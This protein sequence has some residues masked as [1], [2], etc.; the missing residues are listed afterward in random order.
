M[1]KAEL[2]KQIDDLKRAKILKLH[3]EYIVKAKKQK[4][5]ILMIIRMLKNA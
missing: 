1:T 4:K 3:D 5:N 2:R